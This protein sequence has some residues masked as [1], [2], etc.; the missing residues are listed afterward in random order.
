[1]ALP[2]ERSL[3]AAFFSVSSGNACRLT[4]PAL[5]GLLMKPVFCAWWT[6]A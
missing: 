1:M 6:K 2:I 4:M 3:A 5:Q